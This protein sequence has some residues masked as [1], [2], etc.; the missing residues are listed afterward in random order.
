MPTAKGI[1]IGVNTETQKKKRWQENLLLRKYT[2]YKG[3]SPGLVGSGSKVLG[4]ESRRHIL[5]GHLDIFLIDLLSKLY[6]LFEKT[7]NKWKEAKVGPIFKKY[8]SYKQFLYCSP[9][10]VSLTISIATA[11]WIGGS[12]TSVK[13][14]LLNQP[15]NCKI[16]N[17][18][19]VDRKVVGRLY[20]F[21]NAMLKIKL[22]FVVFIK[23]GHS[24]PLFSSCSFFQYSL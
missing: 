6:C 19:L 20:I 24:R 12:A 3:G 23:L 11:I 4:F 9:S 1:F 16:K 14:A 7:E 13:I 21:H 17:W 2:S 22:F 15:K 10:F 5:D 18:G 8:F